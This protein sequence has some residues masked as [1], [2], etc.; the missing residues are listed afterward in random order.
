MEFL[1]L[2]LKHG[3]V[4]SIDNQ[5]LVVLFAGYVVDFLPLLVTPVAKKV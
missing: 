1:L 5:L 3:S 2:I 4:N